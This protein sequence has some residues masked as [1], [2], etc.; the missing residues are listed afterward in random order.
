VA[1]F[2]SLT[3]ILLI[4]DTVFGHIVASARPLF[5]S[6]A[7]PLETVMISVFANE[8]FGSKSFSGVVGLFSA[9][10][11]AGFALASPFSQLW[12]RLFGSY[13][14]AM[15]CFACF[16]L[17]VTVTMHIVVVLANRDRQAIVEAEAALAAGEGEPKLTC[18][19]P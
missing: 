8:L 2:L 14:Y 13:N 11:T 16:M 12:D 4:S 18:N 9:A 3:C 17:F 19:N 10:T 6:V 1:A 7:L 15:I 5:S